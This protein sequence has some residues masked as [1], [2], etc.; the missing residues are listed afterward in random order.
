ME[1]TDAF[2]SMRERQRAPFGRLAEGTPLLELIGNDTQGCDN[3]DTAEDVGTLIY[4]LMTPYPSNI[5]NIS[6]V[7]IVYG[8]WCGYFFVCIGWFTLGT[9]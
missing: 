2:E 6:S 3:R 7:S 4:A 5:N 9:D 1:D 8:F